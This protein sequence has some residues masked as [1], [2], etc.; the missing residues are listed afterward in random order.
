MLL[1]RFGGRIKRFIVEDPTLES[2]FL[3][4]TGRELRDAPASARERT[5]QFGRR[6]GEHTR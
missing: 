1:S 3:S 2:V 4:L 6:G 5:F